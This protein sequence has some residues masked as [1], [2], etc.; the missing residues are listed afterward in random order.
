MNA[1]LFGLIFGV[2]A[3]IGIAAPLVQSQP[4]NPGAPVSG[5]PANNDCAKFVVSGG[6]VQSITTAGASCSGASGANPSATAGPSA[7]NGVATTYLR[8]DGAPAVQKG[9]DAQFGIVMGDG[10]TLKCSA[11]SGV[12]VA[13]SLTFGGQSV[14]PGGSATVQGNGAKVQLST[15]TATSGDCVKF[16]ANGNTIANGA[17]CATQSSGANPSATGGPT[18]VNGSASTFMRSDGAP[19][20][21]KGTNSQFGIVEGD[22]T[23]L[24][25]DATPGVCIATINGILPTPTRAGDI[26]YWNGSAWVALAGN[27]SGTQVLQETS[28]GVPSWAAAGSGTVQSVTPGAGLV[29]SVT[30]SCSQSAITLTGTISKAECINAQ[31]GTTYAVADGDRA[32]VITATNA[33][34]QAYSIAQAGAASAFAS[35]WY[36][37]ISNLSTNVAG[38]V[39]VTPTT[40][41]INGA[42]TLKIQPG[43]SVRIVS[44]GTNYQV[45][46][47][48]SGSQLPGTATNDDANAGNV[49]EYM[50]NNLATGS[51]ISLTTGTVANIVTI[52]LTPG[53]WQVGANL[54]CNGASTTGVGRC[55]GSVSA[56]SAT[57]DT[58]NGRVT[59]FPF[60]A[61]ANTLTPFANAPI[62][63]NVGPARFS[64]SSNTQIWGNV[65]AAFNTSTANAYGKIWARRVR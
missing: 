8:S 47:R 58:T 35:G 24:K 36:T 3:F 20:I 40:S 32:K 43:Q 56:T 60:G 34:A 64:V 61:A 42:S 17:A 18:A 9:T 41:T 54:Y 46:F 2:A 16:D 11:V 48:G 31:T 7:V 13:Q 6:N 19:A 26:V 22:G 57:Q 37:D 50:E 51:A 33:A 21:Q 52:T 45:T 4:F 27:N 44:D 59:Q 15:G 53:D 62:A 25:C 39:T 49:G 5:N 65:V 30:A 28:S 63:V 14:A 55:E 10:A 1:K 12:C 29:S 23:T 38:I